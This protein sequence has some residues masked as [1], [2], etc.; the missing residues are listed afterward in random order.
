MPIIAIIAAIW[1]AWLG[2]WVT[3]GLGVAMMVV[4]PTAWVLALAP[5]LG[6][7]WLANASSRTTAAQA[8]TPV[9]SAW[10]VLVVVVQV[11]LLCAWALV[12]F[13][14]FEQRIGNA[15]SIPFLIWGAS[16]AIS[17]LG[18]MEGHEGKNK[19]RMTKFGSDVATATFVVLVVVHILTDS[20]QF[21]IGAA[22][23]V[24][25]V[26][27]VAM[28]IAVRHEMASDAAVVPRAASNQERPDERNTPLLD[29]Q[30]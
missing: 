24:A 3:L 26:A 8:P 18:Y 19:N 16:V 25:L 6:P 11:L 15:S 12:V 23:V 21:R 9:M 2:E 5:L 17:P 14:V 28:T 1:L 30:D 13:L 27:A 10:E 7:A 20:L 4:M 22:S 29:R